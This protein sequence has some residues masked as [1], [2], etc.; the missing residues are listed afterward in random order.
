MLIRGILSGAAAGLSPL[1]AGLKQAGGT[2]AST[3]SSAGKPAGSAAAGSS[4]S[5]ANTDAL[6]SLAAQYDVSRITPREFSELLQRLR[7]AKALSESDLQELAGIRADLE[8][9]GIE[10]DQEIDLVGF[11]RRR[12]AQLQDGPGKTAPSADPSEVQ[13]TRRRLAWLVR[14]AL[15]HREPEASAL[16]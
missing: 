3:G 2:S 5:P 15:W 13:K 10:P 14:L 8:H 7:Q 1:W 6:R 11:Y 16:A 9:E 12:L 4:S